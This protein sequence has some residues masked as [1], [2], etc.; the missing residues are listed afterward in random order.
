MIASCRLF[1]SLTISPLLDVYKCI[2]IKWASQVN[3]CPPKLLQWTSGPG[4]PGSAAATAGRGDDLTTYV[5]RTYCICVRKLLQRLVRDSS[6]L[7]IIPPGSSTALTGKSA[8]PPPP[9]PPPPP[10]FSPPSIY[11]GQKR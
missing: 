10:P 3:Y 4:P 6:G 2:K 9:P 1:G 7:R 5:Y 8:T 11:W